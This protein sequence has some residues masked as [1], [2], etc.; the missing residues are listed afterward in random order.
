MNPTFGCEPSGYLGRIAGARV[1]QRRP[2]GSFGS[3]EPVLIIHNSVGPRND[4]LH[5]DI[6]LFALCV[7]A[8]MLEMTEF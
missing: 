4:R 8:Q 5:G 7:S 6:D 1:R 3:T 2:P